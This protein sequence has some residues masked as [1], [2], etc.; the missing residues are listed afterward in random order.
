MPDIHT[1]DSP[2]SPPASGDAGTLAPKPPTP[3][4]P[5]PAAAG[6][7]GLKKMS[8]TAGLGTGDYAAVS[9]VAVAALVAGFLGLL[10][11]LSDFLLVVPAIAVVLGVLGVVQVRRSNGT[12]T[13]MWAAVVAILLGVGVGGYVVGGRAL[14]EAALRPDRDQVLA[15]LDAFGKAVVATD[16]AAAY[17]LCDPA[18][19][20]R[21]RPADF[22]GRLAGFETGLAGKL[23]TVDWNGQLIF[24]A[25]DNT[26]GGAGS[27][28]AIG[29][30]L[31]HFRNLSDP[32]RVEIVFAKV[33]GKWVIEDL[34]G[35]FPR[36][37]GGR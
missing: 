1:P 25:Q 11:L 35:L 26:P 22:N 33:N 28:R 16:Y 24:L 18:F 4:T 6:L 15:T 29:G 30:S 9:P 17:Q 5:V 20:A 21:V 3:G 13:W 12:L 34:P 36:N 8:T 7:A 27:T 19:R 32:A 31:F 2:S 37:Q 10:A 23:H 14:R